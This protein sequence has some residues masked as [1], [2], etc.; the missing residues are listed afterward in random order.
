MFIWFNGSVSRW[1]LEGRCFKSMSFFTYI[2][3]SETSGMW[4]YSHSDDPHRRLGQLNSD[5]N[6]STKGRGPWELIFLRE[7]ATKK[8]ATNFESKLK[9]LRN[10]EYIK[11]TFAQYFI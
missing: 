9:K 7:F 5:R 6:K 11:I 8:E 3:Q 4:Y 10:K 2:L 1:N